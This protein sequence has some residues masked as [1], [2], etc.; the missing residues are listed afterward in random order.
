MDNIATNIGRVIL[1]MGIEKIKAPHKIKVKF[2]DLQ[3]SC[4]EVIEDIFTTMKAIT[5]TIITPTACLNFT[6]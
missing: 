6:S 3:F 5:R 1:K 2:S 4:V